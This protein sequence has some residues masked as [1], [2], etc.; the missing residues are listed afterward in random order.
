MIAD[1]LYSNE[2]HPPNVKDM[3]QK[4]TKSNNFNGLNID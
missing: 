4:M 2:F 1:L 3:R